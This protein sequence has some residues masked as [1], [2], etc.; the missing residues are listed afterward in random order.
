MIKSHDDFSTPKIRKI[1]D[2]K[3]GQIATEYL[4]L[5]GIAFLAIIPIFYY[6]ISALSETVRFNEAEDFVNS[7]AKTADMVYA[8]GPG[9]QDYIR[10][11]IPGSTKEIIF[12]R[13]EVILKL[14]FHGKIS[15]VFAQS[16]TNLTGSVSAF[17]GSKHVYAKT[18]GNGTV[19]I[20]EL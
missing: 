12:D 6:S 13:N 8:S 15:D 2:V 5:V 3:R 16:K 1:F 20:G 18:L 11:N 19:E 7:I 14:Y 17:S 10:V 4:L 9:S